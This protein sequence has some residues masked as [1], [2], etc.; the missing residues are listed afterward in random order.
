MPAKNVAFDLGSDTSSPL[1]PADA[2]RQRRREGERGGRGETSARGYEAEDDSE[3]TLDGRDKRY[4]THHPVSETESDPEGAAQYD[5]HHHRSSRRRRSTAT[6]DDPRP[7]HSRDDPS[8]SSQQRSHRS[9]KK[10]SSR[11]RDRDRGRD[12]DYDHDGPLSPAGSDATINLPDRFDKDGRR[13]PERGDDAFADIVQDVLAPDG[14]A[15]KFIKKFLGR[16]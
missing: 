3:S 10:H 11:D 12:Y 6:D 2:R 15:P 5:R 9:S 7:S 13:K 1:A 16:R 8:S 14:P 4:P